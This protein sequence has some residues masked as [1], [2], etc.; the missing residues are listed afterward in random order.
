MVR[1]N[2]FTL[3]EMLASMAIL[4]ILM[5]FLFQFLSSAQRAWSLIETNTRIYEN[6]RVA[7]DLITRDLQCAVAS[8][9]EDEEIPFYYA[10]GQPTFVSATPLPYDNPD[11]RLCEITYSFNP[12]D[13]DLER[14]C[15]SDANASNKWGDFFSL[16]ATDWH[17]NGTVDKEKVING[18]EAMTITCYQGTSEMADTTNFTVLPDYALVSLTLYDPKT[19]EA[20]RGATK[21]TFTKI[22]TFGR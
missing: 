9:T 22:I 2:S 3:V 1:K 7:L 18:V 10:T 15:I 4:V 16:A 5:G 11:S 19:V 12:T 8:D 17:D 14:Q 21:R 13:N 6:A 20:K